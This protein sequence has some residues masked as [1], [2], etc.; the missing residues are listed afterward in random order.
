MEITSTNRSP[1][2]P[3]QNPRTVENRQAQ[4]YQAEQRKAAQQ[5][6]EE[7]KRDAQP[8]VNT[9]GQTTGRIVN[10]TA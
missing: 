6:A 2:P 1:S 10:T 4:Q 9:Q 3:P 5:A 7:K 8:R